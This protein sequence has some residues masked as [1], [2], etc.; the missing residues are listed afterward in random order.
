[1]KPWFPKPALMLIVGILSIQI[2]SAQPSLEFANGQGPTTN[3]SSIASQTVTWE[4][5]AD[6]PTGNTFTSFFPTTTVTFSLS[7]QQYVLNSGQSPNGASVSFGGNLNNSGQMI[8][9]TGIYQPM[10]FISSAPAGDFSSLPSTIGQGI[11]MTANYGIEVFTSTMG[12]YNAGFVTAN[13]YY[14]AD[15]TITFSNPVTN[16]VLQLVGIGGY[17]SSGSGR[18]GFT[19]EFDLVTA[20]VTLSRLSGSPEL[21]ITSTNILNS[22]VHPSSLT[23]AGAASGSILVTGNNITQL[24]FQ[25][26]LRGDGGNASWAGPTQHVGDAWVLG[27]SEQSSMVVLPVKISDFTARPHG[28]NAWLQWAASSEQNSD[29]F[30]VEYSIDGRSWQ[31][32][33]NVRA[34]GNSTMPKRYSFVHYSPTAGNNLYRIAEVDADGSYSYTPVQKVWFAQAG[35]TLRYYPN[36]VRDRV[37]VITGSDQPRSVSVMTIDGRILQQATSFH[38][39]K[40]IDLSGYPGGIY[41]LKISDGGGSL[42]VLKVQKE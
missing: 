39:E 21:N 7:N 12:L 11:S 14:M 17:Y 6:N 13:R 22:A 1:M 25:V 20:G 40:S 42:Q 3:G 9:G 8:G 33:G 24:V 18:L 19:T 26:Y 2:L 34:T 28:N 29:H 5:N 35:S 30:D 10:N 31:S 16:P 37:T 27:V 23:G 38:S 4:N 15:L 32:I 41:I 36:P